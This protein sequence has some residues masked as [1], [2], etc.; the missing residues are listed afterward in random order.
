MNFMVHGPDINHFTGKM[1][2]RWAGALCTRPMEAGLLQIAKEAQVRGPVSDLFT[3]KANVPLT[4]A[5]IAY[6]DGQYQESVAQA[7]NALLVKP[8]FAPAYWALGISYGMSG[9]WNLAI[10]NLEAALKIDKNYGDAK[11]ALK[12][13]Q[14][15]QK[16]AKDGK[17]PKAQNPQWN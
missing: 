3:L 1:S 15:G 8:D 5:R 6:Q 2:T 7:K 4:N 17:S 16:A 9:Q 12:W 13:A 11:D 14:Q 10:T